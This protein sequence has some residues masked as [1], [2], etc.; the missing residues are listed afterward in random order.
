MLNQNAAV[1]KQLNMLA[2]SPTL[3]SQCLQV[4]HNDIKTKNVLLSKEATVAKL[5]DVGTSRL[6]DQTCT[7][8]S[9]STMYTFAYAAP[10]Q[11]HGERET[12]TE[13]VLLKGPAIEYMF[14]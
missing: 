1:A 6:L 2:D 10:E 12:C 3:S 4:V 14:A 11:L 5:S 9:A 13:K 7:T 8:S